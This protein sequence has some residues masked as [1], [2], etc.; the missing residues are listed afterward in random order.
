M[1]YHGVRR[2]GAGCLYRVGVA[3]FDLEGIGRSPSRFDFGKLENLNG[4]YI[5]QTP[6]EELVAHVVALL[7]HI[8]EGAALKAK[9]NADKRAQLVAAMPGLKER[10]KTLLELIDNA[11]FLFAVRPL[12]PDEKAVALLVLMSATGCGKYAAAALGHPV[13]PLPSHHEA[14]QKESDPYREECKRTKPLFC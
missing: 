14:R 13:D 1:L 6:D 9:L 7:D 12:V 2:T 11:G 8:P 4:H 5:R 3:L 10:A